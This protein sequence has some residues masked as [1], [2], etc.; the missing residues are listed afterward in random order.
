MKPFSNRVNI[1]LLIVAVGLLAYFPIDLVTVLS[2]IA[3]FSGPIYP[4]YISI[5]ISALTVLSIVTSIRT[6]IKWESNK[7]NT[8]GLEWSIKC[9]KENS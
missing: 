3:V 7:G 2:G 1:P 9:Q 8:R 6:R 5:G 4:L